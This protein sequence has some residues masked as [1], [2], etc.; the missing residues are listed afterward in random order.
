MHVHVRIVFIFKL[1]VAQYFEDVE[2]FF[3]VL[4]FM[5]R[6]HWSSGL[7]CLQQLVSCRVCV[8]CRRSNRKAGPPFRS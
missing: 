6:V 8:F 3:G 1:V 7:G 2:Y 4:F 5:A